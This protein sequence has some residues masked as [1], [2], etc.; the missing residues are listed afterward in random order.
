MT[1]SRIKGSTAP[2]T[3]ERFDVVI[4]G[5]GISGIGCAYM[6]RQQCPGL[7]FVILEYMESYGGTWLLHKYPGTRSDSD[8]YTFGYHFKPWVGKP[9]AT[10]QE[11]LDYLGSVIQD[12]NLEP[13]I[14]YR[15]QIQS[16]NWSTEAKAWKLDVCVD[17]GQTTSMEAGFLWMCQGYYRHDRGYTPEWP[18]MSKFKGALIHPQHWPEHIDM[19]AKRVTV[20]GSGA[21]AATLIPAL[22]DQCA[23]VTML[24]R[25]PTFFSTGQ[26]AD[27]LADELRKLEIDEKWIHEIMRRKVVKERSDLIRRARSR[28]DALKEQ[29]IEGI[30]PHLPEG[31]DVDRHF[32]PPYK[33]LQQ[34]V[35]FVPEGDLFAAIREGKASVV[36]DHIAQFDESGIQLQ[37]GE[38]IDCDVVVTATGFELSVMGEIPFSVDGNP[39]DFSK[40]ISYRGTMFSGIPNLAWVYG[41]G[42]YSW[43]LRVELVGNF[44][45]RLL[46]HMRS[47]R[48]KSVSPTLRPEDAD[49][50]LSPW[51][52]PDDLNAGYMMR[53]LHR[54]PKKGSKPEW[55]HSQDYVYER[56]AFP[57]ID[58]RDPIFAYQD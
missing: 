29:L 9:I 25:T 22:A 44:V 12:G 48:L 56:S 1:T 57:A 34:R 7:S 50:E 54:L 36:T 2:P 15:H 27:A 21:T 31:F 19:S 32:R 3:T 14:R 5:A 8:L 43:T 16:A 40:T 47:H 33:P 10:R 11:I 49:M 30:T 26:N 55:Q 20:I 4:V 37:S 58:L 46:S 39:V 23:H 13:D 38:R 52:D 53:S 18:G 24:Q 28:P 45:C 17:G 42:R 6:L 35:A 51:I 41:Y